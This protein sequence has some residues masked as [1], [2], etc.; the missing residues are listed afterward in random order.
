MSSAVPTT[1]FADETKLAAAVTAGRLAPGTA[2]V[3]YA[4]GATR[5]TPVVQQRDPGAYYA[6]AAQIAH[7][8]DL[9]FIAAP[10]LSLVTALAPATLPDGRDRAF[11][12][13]GLA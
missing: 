12:R 6:M 7:E 1:S 11:L 10:Q 8:H 13:L 4:A 9:L 2:A 5:A 3:V